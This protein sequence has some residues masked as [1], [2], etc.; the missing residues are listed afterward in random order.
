MGVARMLRPWRAVLQEALPG[1]HG[2]QINGLAEASWAMIQAEHCQL[3]KMAVTTGQT[4]KVPS[5]ERRWQRLVAN[6]R[7][8]PA[9]VMEDWAEWQ[10]S[11]AQAVTLFLDETPQGNRLR[12][13]KIS[14]MTGGRAI[15]LLWRS[16]RPDAPGPGQ[17]QIVSHLLQRLARQ[18]PPGARPTLMADRGLAW[19]TVVDHCRQ[20]GWHF[21]LRVPGH[22]RVRLPFE[23]SQPIRKLAPRPGS[24]WWGRGEVFKKA[25]WRSVHVVAWWSPRRSEPWLLVT[26]LPANWRR[27]RQ[28]RKRMRQEQSFR[29]EKS[30]GFRWAESR[31]RRPVHADRLL[32]VMALATA[33]LIRLGLQITREGRRSHYARPDR[34]TLSLFQLG[35][36]CLQDQL[37]LAREPPLFKSVGR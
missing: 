34:R 30:H 10:L 31:I 16:Y 18:L 36:R 29:D 28:Y 37:I 33:W 19:P 13:M 8:K 25:G 5:R 6:P 1:L 24:G 3:S 22:C 12:T 4:A 20:E 9:A 17:D 26:D 7:L 23:S 14:R 32:L 11:D 21:L 2:H 27:C 35:L 15:P